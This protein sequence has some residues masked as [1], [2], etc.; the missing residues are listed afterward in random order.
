M[1]ARAL[2]THGQATFSSGLTTDRAQLC[3]DPLWLCQQPALATTT[4]EAGP[5]C[6]LPQRR[7]IIPQPIRPNTIFSHGSASSPAH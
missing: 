4:V 1:E 6:G 5:V 7:T 3:D 2:S